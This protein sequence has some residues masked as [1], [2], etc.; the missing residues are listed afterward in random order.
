MGRDH[1]RGGPH[2][3]QVPWAQFRGRAGLGVG[4]EVGGRHGGECRT[5]FR[6]LGDNLIVARW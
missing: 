6:G 5:G 1:N 3:G 2:T 4:V